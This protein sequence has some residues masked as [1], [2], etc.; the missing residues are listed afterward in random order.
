M[1][2]LIISVHGIRTFG[3]WQERLEKLIIIADPNPELT[4]INYKYGYFSTIGFLIPFLRWLVVRR[5][6]LF[7][8]NAA[9]SKPWERIDLV[10]HSFG[11]HIVAW[12][13]YGLDEKDRPAVNTLILAGSVLKSNFPWQVLL[14]HSVRRLVNDCGIKDQVLVLN[15]LVV[16]FTGMAGRLG[17][18]A[19]TGRTFRNR[20]F[21]FGHSGYFLTN[22]QSDDMFMQRYWL[23]L[24]IT[25][26]DPE[27]VDVRM[28]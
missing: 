25:D 8:L 26:A 18:N 23:P 7:L 22:R 4:V 24:L 13:L 12:A 19:G 16:L 6:R 21:D 17:F 28:F 9:K 10:A 14:G 27:L 15:Q 3:N 11:T 2:Q 20:F 5:F 1:K